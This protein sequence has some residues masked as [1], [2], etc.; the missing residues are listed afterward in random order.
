MQTYHFSYFSGQELQESHNFDWLI[1]HKNIPLGIKRKPG[2]PSRM[3]KALEFQDNEEYVFS[4]SD[5]EVDAPLKEKKTKSKKRNQPI[6]DE[7]SEPEYDIFAS[8]AAT[9]STATRKSTR[10]NKEQPQPSKKSKTLINIGVT[11]NSKKN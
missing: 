1:E 8:N 9:S 2:R 6:V 3:K 4:D 10:L 11:K 5:D 7:E